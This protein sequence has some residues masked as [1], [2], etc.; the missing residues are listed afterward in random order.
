VVGRYRPNTVRSV[1]LDLKVFCT[2]LA[3]D[4]IEVTPADLFEFVAD[5]R[6]DRSVVRLSDRE[7]VLSAR[8]I[9]CRL[10]PAVVVGVLCA[11]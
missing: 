7:S 10:P 1:A 5:Q 9:A 6:G 8:T 2:V 11:S 4:P 3:K